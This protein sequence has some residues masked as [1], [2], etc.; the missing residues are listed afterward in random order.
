MGSLTRDDPKDLKRKGAPY[1]SY[2]IRFE[3]D[4][5]YRIDLMSKAFDAYLRLEGPDGTTVAQDDDSGG[6]LNAR[7]SYHSTKAGNYRIIATTYGATLGAFTLTVQEEAT[8]KAIKL[9]LRGGKASAASTLSKDDP[10]DHGGGFRKNPCKIYAV[11]LEANRAYRIDHMSKDFDAYLRLEGPDGKAIAEDDDSGGSLNARIELRAWTAGTY[12]V[13][14]TMNSSAKFGAF[15]LS[16]QEGARVP[17]VELKNGK[18][19]VESRLTKDDP[20]DYGSS[21]LSPSRAY[22]VRLEANEVY[23]IDLR[24]K[25]FD[26]YLRLI[27]P[28]GKSVAEN[29]DSTDGLDARIEYRCPAAGTYRIIAKSIAY[30]QKFGDFVLT[31]QHQ[32]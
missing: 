15:N 23:R 22:L 17:E 26:S 6:D 3:A 14:A 9:E 21:T 29:D 1:K 28:D 20:R 10:K 7:I 30:P 18:A 5:R 19:Q 8:A 27:G 12:R 25:Q 32:R 24:S 4:R 31:V 11:Q 13:I 2:T 16:V